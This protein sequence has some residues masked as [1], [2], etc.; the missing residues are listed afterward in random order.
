MQQSIKVKLNEN[1]KL[2]EYLKYESYWY[3][4]LN[5]NTLNYDMYVNYIK[6]K[7]KLRITD[8][9]NDFVNNIDTISS[10]LEVFK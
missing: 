1:I 3:K 9:V 8:K 4:E 6:E 7:Y 10:V 5:R 2:K